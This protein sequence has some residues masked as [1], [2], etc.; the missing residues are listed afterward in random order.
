MSGAN[1]LT[2]LIKKLFPKKKC[3]NEDLKEYARKLALKRPE[4]TEK[5]YL[6][7]DPVEEKSGGEYFAEKIVPT[8]TGRREKPEP[9]RTFA[10][11]RKIGKRA[12][13]Y[14]NRYVSTDPESFVKQAKFMEN[15][16][17]NA[18]AE[19]P[20]EAYYTTYAKMNDAQLRTYF[21][22]RTGVREGIIKNVSVSYA[23][24]Y[25][26]ELLNGIGVKTPE[27]TVNKLI[28]IWT[29]F[30]KFDKSIDAYM[31]VW[32]R[33]YYIIHNKELKYSFSDY[34]N[35][36]PVLYYGFDAE[37]YYGIKSGKYENLRAVEMFSSFKITDG[38]F[39]KSGNSDIIEKCVC[40]TLK[41]ISKL[42]KASGTDFKKL[43]SAKKRETLYSFYRGA[44]YSPIK[45]YEAKVELDGIETFK[46]GS[47][48]FRIESP[49]MLK[50][51]AV[52]GYI[53]KLTE[54]K[55]RKLFGHKRALKS[56]DIKTVEKGLFESEERTGYYYEGKRLFDLS[57]WKRKIL[58]TMYDDSFEETIE[59]A[60]VDFLKLS[61]IVVKDGKLTEIKPVEI[62]MSK[63][64][65]IEEDHIETAKKLISEEETPEEIPQKKEAEES[66]ELSGF[67]GFTGVIALLSKEA[68]ALLL[69]L[70]NNETTGFNTE[71]S[72]EEINEKALDIIG[73]NLIGY[74]SGEPRIYEEYIDEVKEA[75]G[76]R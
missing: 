34:R 58:E 31:R 49:D 50:Y 70:V 26:Y 47:K 43:F 36:F 32:I 48:G 21:T 67:T 35:R 55:M 63:L 7:V 62:D 16:T 17:D 4:K 45:F 3:S 37:L 54:V 38:Q 73:D 66:T 60:A 46:Y 39:Y 8:L 42:F 75:L 28:S 41:E 74:V 68:K 13:I 15:F 57:L 51:R 2:E 25:I 9:Y 23:Y 61:N 33:D 72:V 71:L 6:L 14:G 52:I 30:R 12:E 18:E 19:V 40:F 20:L 64:K 69:H 76:G 65:K 53:L 24:C 10:K 11:M 56:P 44:V 22:W 29:S 1:S 27:D 59:R 5:G